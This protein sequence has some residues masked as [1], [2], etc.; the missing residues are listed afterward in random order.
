M[1]TSL[2]PRVPSLEF[3]A[4]ADLLSA[5]SSQLLAKATERSDC[6]DL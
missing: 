2:Q 5:L 6:E 1:T 3:L 4:A